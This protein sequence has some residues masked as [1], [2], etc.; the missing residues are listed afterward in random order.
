MPVNNFKEGQDALERL[1]KAV[2]PFV[3]RRLKSD[4]LKDLPEKIVQDYICTMTSLQEKLY[5]H[6]VN[7]CQQI[8]SH[9]EMGGD[10]LTPLETISELRKCI[11]HPALVSSDCLRG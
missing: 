4:V 2:L 10:N 9:S 7:M 11:V 5:A 1:H 3:L 8:N 6:I